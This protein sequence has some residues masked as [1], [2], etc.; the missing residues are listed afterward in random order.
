LVIVT[1][2]HGEEFFDHGQKGH[3][4][5]LHAESVHVPLIVKYPRGGPRGSDSRL[6]SLVDVFPTI[7]DVTG[8]AGEWTLA[9]RSLLAPGVDPDHAI[10]HELRA[11]RYGKGAS[12]ATTERQSYAI[13][14]GDFKLIVVPDE[15][16]IALYNVTSDPQERNDLSREDEARAAEL[17]AILAQWRAASRALAEGFESGGE[18]QLDPEAL[19]RLRALGYIR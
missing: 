15:G 8:D 18:A 1:A 14:K 11:T 19:D 6:A 4:N 10:F 7:L 9:G 12:K 5:N 16:R 3:M 2:D 17:G 13:R